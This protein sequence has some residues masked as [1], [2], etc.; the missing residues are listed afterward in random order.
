MTKMGK[1]WGRGFTII[2]LVAVLGILAIMV[3]IALPSS[4]AFLSRCN[5]EGAARGLA[6][7]LRFIRQEAITSG[8]SSSIYFYITD[9]R[10][11][12]R[13]M[14][15]NERYN[16][17][18]PEGIDF[19]GKTTFSGD[20]PSVVFNKMGRPSG[21]GGTIVLKSSTGEMR[22]VIV[23]PVTGRIRISKDPPENW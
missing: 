16:V 6:G 21:R 15:K 17:R 12:V 2:E 18:L 4:A 13:L 10:Y 1:R 11:Q 19:E 9:K 3:A 14:E 20:H 5:L 7:D 8:I 23:L 22:F